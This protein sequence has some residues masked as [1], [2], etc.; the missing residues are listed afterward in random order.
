M[1]DKDSTDIQWIYSAE[2]EKVRLVSVVK[3]AG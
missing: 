1:K 2:G 3:T